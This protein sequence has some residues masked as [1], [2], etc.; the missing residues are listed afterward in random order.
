[1]AVSLKG[2]GHAAERQAVSVIADGLIKSLRSKEDK[3]EVYEKII[4]LAAHFWGKNANAETLDKV[5]AVVADPENRWVKFIGKVLDETDPQYAKKMLLNL[6]YEAFF[7]G[8]KTIREN[9]E[10]YGC[11]IPWLIL[12]DPT[13]ACN[14]HCVGCWSGTY[15]SKTSLTFEE[16]DK[17]VT[18][19]KA[20]GVYL[21]MMTGG[22]PMVRKKDIL[23]LCEKHNDCF[24]AA[25][26]NST[27]IDD[28][29]CRTL[30]ASAT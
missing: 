8:T 26:I 30:S 9:R 24:F 29:L 27:L 7:R 13:N 19:G 2:L 21:Y 17:I 28:Q 5:R 16:M 23:K 4:D 6:G 18:E 15:G 12:F 22:E 11:N 1:M 20:L 25:Y 3:T 10:K 14:M